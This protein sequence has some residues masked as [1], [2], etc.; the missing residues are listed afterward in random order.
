MN[1]KEDAG[2]QVLKSLGLLASG[3][4]W[5]SHLP[6]FLERHPS[7][8]QGQRGSVKRR[9]GLGEGSED[10]DEEAESFQSKGR[11][12]CVLALAPDPTPYLFHS[13]MLADPSI[14]LLPSESRNSPG[15][16]QGTHQASD[17][18]LLLLPIAAS[19]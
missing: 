4:P 13:C 8:G 5:L 7:R 12:D 15:E 11:L 1:E 6:C 10:Q 17:V 14:G 18:P 19:G 9:K 16:P 2:C 3:S